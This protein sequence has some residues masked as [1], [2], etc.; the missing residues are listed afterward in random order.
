MTVIATRV[1]DSLDIAVHDKNGVIKVEINNTFVNA[2]YTRTE[3][4]DLLTFEQKEALLDYYVSIY[5]SY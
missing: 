3:D 4:W 5:R 2:T 1:E